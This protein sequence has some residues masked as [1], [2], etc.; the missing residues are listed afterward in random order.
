M[1]SVGMAGWKD[2]FVMTRHERVGTIVLLAVIT[3]LVVGDWLWTAHVNRSAQQQ[4]QQQISAEMVV[5]YLRQDTTA[6]KKD[7]KRTSL[8]KPKKSKEAAQKS[9]SKHKSQK[10]SS[11]SKPSS[12]P[13]RRSEP[14]PQF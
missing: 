1:T 4:S 8:R 3:L 11:E 7:K 6:H 14:V 13:D 5:E 2:Y 12:L 10:K 9:R